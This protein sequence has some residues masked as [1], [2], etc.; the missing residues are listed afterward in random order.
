[1]PRINSVDTL[2]LLAIIAII[3][4]HTAPFSIAS[5]SES[6]DF[7]YYLTIFINQV[8]RFAVPLF[9]VISGY[10]YG[11]K[12]RQGF[13]P[14]T[15]SYKMLSRI[16]ILYLTWC[17]IYLMPYNLSAIVEFGILGP[18][19]VAYWNVMRLVDQPITFLFEGSKVHLWFLMSLMICIVITALLLYFKQVNLLVF[20]SLC[21]FI[22]AVLAK[23]YSATRFGVNIE[24][25]TRNGPF[26]GLIFFVTGY[27][28]TKYK[29]SMNWLYYGISV[30]IL[31]CFLH[32]YEI[33]Y[34]NQTYH[35]SP[36]QDFVFG[37][38]FMGIG[39]AMIALSNHKVLCN[40][41]AVRLGKMTLGIYA[42]HF[43]FVDLLRP[44]DK[45][46]N[47]PIW[48]VSFVILVLLFSISFTKFLAMSKL[49]KKI[50]E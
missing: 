20:I 40:Q 5:S 18:I 33:I 32:F 26:F 22:F 31:G 27:Y 8:A 13:C 17:A 10:F 28:F 50:V 12:I 30:F 42:S 29:I 39:A 9:F 38:Y 46:F 11:L 37:T 34:L 47:H 36:L 21:F 15:I 43:I 35:V 49:G 48:E 7:Y 4:I 1:M 23:S 6:N 16:L 19:K 2:K 41:L 14:L 45:E 44:L 24:F 25:N 3:S